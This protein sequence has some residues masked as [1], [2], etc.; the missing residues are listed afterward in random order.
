MHELRN[1]DAVCEIPAWSGDECKKNHRLLPTLW[2]ED[3]G[4]ANVW[5]LQIRA[6]RVERG[7]DMLRL[8]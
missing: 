5:R 4:D 6:R 8:P 1:V 7:R 3:D 2:Q